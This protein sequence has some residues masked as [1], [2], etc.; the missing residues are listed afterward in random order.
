MEWRRGARLDHALQVAQVLGKPAETVF[1]PAFKILQ[2][3]GVRSDRELHDLAWND[4]DF[5]RELDKVGIDPHPGAWTLKVHFLGGE[6]H[7]WPISSGDLDRFWH[8]VE[9]AEY[10][11]VEDRFF[12]FD[13][14]DVSV[15]FSLSQMAHAHA[16][17][18]ADTPTETDEEE[19]PGIAV[20]LAGEREWLTFGADFDEPDYEDIG[21]YQGQLNELLVDLEQAQ[22]GDPYVAFDDEDKER[23]V[24][25]V[26]ALVPWKQN[27]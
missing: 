9:D 24:F 6:T 2:R 11:K 19:V 25:R 21:A 5:R 10:G 16:L 8:Y 14:D 1:A 3:R 22:Y 27:H 12:A 17:V 20:L 4:D 23:A 18:D 15:V 13:S 7:V 26:S